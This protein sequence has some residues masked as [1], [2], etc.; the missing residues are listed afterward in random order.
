MGLLKGTRAYLAGPVERVDDNA[1]WR[2]KIRPLLGQMG[3]TVWDPL[4]KPKWFVDQC[5][6]ELTGDEQRNDLKLLEDR[7]ISTSGRD[8]VKAIMRNTLARDTCLRLVSSCD[9]AICFVG[10]PTVGTFEELAIMNS[11]K[12][13]IIFLHDSGHMDS[14][15]RYV[16]FSEATHK[17]SVD[18]VIDYLNNINNESARV[19]NK[20]WIFLPGRWPDASSITARSDKQSRSTIQKA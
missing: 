10:G 5:G 1:S 20:Q 6:C 17:Y 19:D 16:Q 15:W 14:C 11:Q 13:P 12:K 2:E 7:R 8:V 18:E 9:F 4:I 3:I